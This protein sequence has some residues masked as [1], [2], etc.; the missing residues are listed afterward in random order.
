MRSRPNGRRLLAAWFAWTT[1]SRSNETSQTLLKYWFFLYQDLLPENQYSTWRGEE[2]WRIRRYNLVSKQGMGYLNSSKSV[3]LISL[4]YKVNTPA[5]R[6]SLA[7][8]A[9]ILNP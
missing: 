1:A 7:A 8:E 3:S 6:E 9:R 5:C 2:L 4:L